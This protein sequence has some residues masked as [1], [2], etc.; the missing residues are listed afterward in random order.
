MVCIADLGLAIGNNDKQALMIKCGTPAYV[1]P[2]V[3]NDN[4]FTFKSDIFSLG[5][6][7]FNLITRKFI[8]K[9]RTS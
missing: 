5:S 6:L 8:F 2:E 1:D 4:G 7:M 3:L 9:G